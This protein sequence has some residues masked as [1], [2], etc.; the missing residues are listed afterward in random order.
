MGE[1]NGHRHQ[2]RGLIARIAKHET[3]I[4]GSLLLV[5]PFA[6]RHPLVDIR[7]LL[8]D[9]RQHRTGLRV[10]PELGVGVPDVAHDIPDHLL[11]IDGGRGSDFASDQDQACRDERFARHAPIGILRENGV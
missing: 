10:E 5:E 8:M 2:F 1:H 9:R 4:S 3:L 7:R 11:K 6:F